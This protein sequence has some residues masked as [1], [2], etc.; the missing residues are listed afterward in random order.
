[1]SSYSQNLLIMKKVFITLSLLAF[2]YVSFA[3]KN[4]VQNTINFLKPHNYKLDDAKVSIDKAILHSSTNADYK[5]WYYAGKVYLEIHETKIEK[6]KGLDDN[7]L[8]KSLV[9]YLN[10]IKYDKGK[11]FVDQ[12]NTSVRRIAGFYFNQG[13]N[14]YNEGLEFLSNKDTES[15][16]KNFNKAA[17]SYEKCLE[18]Y[19]IP[20]FT[21]LDTMLILRT[22]L[23]SL[24]GKQYDKALGYF[25]NCADYKF[26]GEEVFI[27]MAVI[28]QIKGDTTKAIQTLEEG[29]KVYPVKNLGILNQLIIY[30]YDTGKTTEALDY[31]NLAIEK[32]P[33]NNGLHHIK[34]ELFK[35]MGNNVKAAESYMKSIELN[36]DFVDSPYNLGIMYYNMAGERHNESNATSD[37]DEFIRLKGEGD[38]L[39][40]L[41][42]PYLEKAHELEPTEPSTLDIL[43]RMTYR[44]GLL[45][46]NREYTQKLKDISK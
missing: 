43:K 20:N 45:D 16:I 11:R 25:K 44:L 38:D 13:T 37:N 19:K 9:A 40:K 42:L 33:D 41:A 34:G 35:Q 12:S 5:A 14:T 36:P 10:S 6:Y 28:Y 24:S 17:E 31:I 27:N 23:A 4:E 1:M 30:Y 26:G 7:P 39:F 2:V 18:I 3:Q 46:K 29:M 32:N 21:K 8:D 15:A 22:G